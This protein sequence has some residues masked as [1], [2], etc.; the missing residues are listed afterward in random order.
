[1]P[2]IV[3][4]YINSVCP[5]FVCCMFSLMLQKEPFRKYHIRDYRLPTT[6]FLK[7]KPYLSQEN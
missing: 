7:S 3:S 5:I 6:S 1:M 2:A 4:L